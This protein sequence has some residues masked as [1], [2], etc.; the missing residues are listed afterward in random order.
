M[1]KVVPFGNRCLCKRRK[2]GEKSGSLYLPEQTAGQDTDL[3]DVVHVPEKTLVDAEILKDVEITISNLGKRL[4]DG[5]PAAYECLEKIQKLIHHSL[6]TVGSPVMIGK[7]VGVTFHDNQGG[8][9]QTLVKLDD[10]IGLVV[11]D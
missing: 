4:R 2:V 1:P 11:D 8:Q 10:I 9:D 3:A 6:I 7:Y 5:E